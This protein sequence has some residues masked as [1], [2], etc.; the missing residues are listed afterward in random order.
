[1][2]STMKRHWKCA[3]VTK[4]VHIIATRTAMTTVPTH[5]PGCRTGTARICS[6]GAGR[7][8]APV[9]SVVMQCGASA[10][11]GLTAKS[12]IAPACDAPLVST[13]L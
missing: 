5:R 9:A 10:G 1:M 11:G 2:F 8:P 3:F 6:G 7:A 12:V 4:H 13:F